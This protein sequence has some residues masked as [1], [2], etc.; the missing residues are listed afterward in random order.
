MECYIR[1]IINVIYNFA[2]RN[3][4]NVCINLLSVFCKI[5]T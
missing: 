1:L 3:H 4:L 2:F 5:H